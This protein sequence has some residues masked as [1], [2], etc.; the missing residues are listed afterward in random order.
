MHGVEH[1]WPSN[2][3]RAMRIFRAT[4]VALSLAVPAGPVNAQSGLLFQP[5]ARIGVLRTAGR[6]EDSGA[7]LKLGGARFR[8]GPA[9]RRAGL[10][11]G[12][13][14]SRR[15]HILIA[16]AIRVQSALCNVPSTGP[17]VNTLMSGIDVEGVIK[18]SQTSQRRFGGGVGTRQFVRMPAGCAGPC[19][20]NPTDATT[21]VLPDPA[22]PS[23]SDAVP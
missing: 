15:A 14:N 19:Q 17:A 4:I 21:G 13:A 5:V 22:R 23:P 11:W 9:N 20:P 3:P 12:R 10:A 7:S 1:P 6:F 8:Y 2:A 16:S 18:A